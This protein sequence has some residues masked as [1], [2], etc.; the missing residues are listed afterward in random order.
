MSVLRT[1]KSLRHGGE[2]QLRKSLGPLDLTLMGIGAIVGAGI[3]VLSGVAAATEAG[4]AVVL[5]YVMAGISCIFAAFC[6]AELASTLGGVGSSYG[7][8]YA[9]L[10]EIF[11][12][13]IGL[14]LLLAYGLSVTSVANGW[15]AYML[16]MLKDFDVVIPEVFAKPD[17]MNG[18]IDLPAFC[19]MIIATFIVASGSSSTAKFNDIVVGIKLTVIVLFIILAIPNVDTANWQPFIP[20]PA[21]NPDGKMAYGV[22]GIISGAALVFFAYIG[23]DAVATAAEEAKNPKRDLPIGIISSLIICTALYIIVSL[24]LTGVES[25]KKLDVGDPVASALQ[26]IGYT[27]GAMVV[28]FG[29][30]AG[31]TTVI[32]V[33]FFAF[34]RLFLGIARDG[35]LPHGMAK[36]SPRTQSPI[37]I[38][39]VGGIFMAV[40]S[41]CTPLSI[42]API[43]NI[44]ILCTFMT[45]C[46]NVIVLRYRRPELERPFKVPLFPVF[47]AIGAILCLYLM[48]NTGLVA[49][50]TLGITLVVGLIFYFAYSYR[51][52]LLGKAQAE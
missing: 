43:V 24:L 7:Y 51:N 37:R 50:I 8:T 14:V 18:S 30:I 38:V 40:L 29:A 2:G 46:I 1:K 26:N 12:W 39:L 52:S 49:W 23:F 45:V 19:I 9:A 31:L 34:T 11:A 48:I 27:W 22:Q 44:G 4:P 41:A 47:P 20:E 13:I 16:Q 36:I 28:S 33:M 6:Y 10:G 32:V 21:L 35:L 17:V 25:Y 15:S 5:S 3:F 42:L